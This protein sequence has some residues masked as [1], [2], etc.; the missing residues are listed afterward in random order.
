MSQEIETLMPHDLINAKPVSAVVKEYFGSSQLS[1]FMDQTNPLSEVTHKRRLSALG[2]G[3]S[4]PRARRLRGARRPP[5]AL[6]PHLPDRD[7]G[8]SEHRPHRVAVDLRA[9]QRVR[10]HRD[11]VPHGRRTAAS[12][13]RSSSTRRC[14]R[15]GTTSPSPTPPID[16]KGKFTDDL[17][18]CRHNE[19]VRHGQAGGGDADG[20][21]A[22]P[23][24]VG[25]RVADPVPRERRR[26]P[27]AHGL[28][29]AAPGG[30]AHPHPLAARRHRH[31][32]HRGARLGRHRGRQA[33][34]RRR[35]GRRD[36][37]RRAPDPGE[38]ERSAVGQ[39][40]HLQPDQVPALQP[41]H[42]H[43][44][45]ADR[46]ARRP[47]PG[48]RR[49]RRRPG[50]RARRAGARARTCWSRSCPGAAT[51]SRTRS[52]SPSGWSRTTTS[53]R[54]TSRSSSASRAT[55]SSARKRSRATS[56]T[57][58]RRPSRTSTSR[59]S[60]AS[61]PRSRPSDI[62]VGKITPKGETQLSPEEKLLRAIFGEKAGDVRDTS[63][64]VPPG[65]QRHRHR[66]PGVRA[67]GRRRRTSAPR[68]SRTP[69]KEK[70]LAD[71]RD[72][73]KIISESLLRQDAQAA[74]RQDHGGAAGRRQGQG[75][76][77]PRAQKI[78]ERDAR[79]G[80]ARATGARSRSTRA[81]A[82]PRSSSSSSPRG[83][84]EDVNAIEAALPRQDR[85]S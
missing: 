25:G 18:S 81:A 44:P 6:R 62:L 49:H 72:E 61:A 55:P 76:A 58:A 77:A 52:S 23:A 15:R 11:A 30:A 83:C 70:L 26:Q 39:A 80:P 36:P 38:R 78:D 7:A 50:D 85:A 13:T 68:T 28:E 16:K 46:R 71:Q 42:L 37:H 12:P 14:R 74:G 20:R 29:H 48:G 54:S 45:E 63:L 24:G 22:E 5:D 34:R 67:Q 33:R 65:V 56:R 73:V 27:R 3:R 75:A 47:G 10:L 53:P 41:E 1:Q 57:S 4:D 82:R 69:E 9:R 2:P 8:R 66:R 60:C 21:V 79:R 51:T 19:R 64:R 17:V 32:G 84:E 59:A 31:R 43:Q 35:V 40:G